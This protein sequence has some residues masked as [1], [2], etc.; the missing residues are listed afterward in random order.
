VISP[1]AAAAIVTYKFRARR[2][3]EPEAEYLGDLLLHIEQRDFAAAHEL[4]VGRRQADWTKADVQAFHEH[5]SRRPRGPREDLPPGFHMQPAID[6]GPIEVSR[7]ALLAYATECLDTLV[8]MRKRRPT[9]ELLIAVSVVLLDGRALATFVGR[10]ER[11]AVVKA[12]AQSHPVFG[13][14]VVCDVFIHTINKTSGT[15]TK[16]DAIICHAGTRDMRIMKVRPYALEH[17]QAVFVNPPPADVD[18]AAEA[19]MISDPYA[20]IFVTVP[21]PTGPPS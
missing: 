15:A 18:K 21:T 13:F 19:G 3:H 12:L 11:V 1:L 4:R 2:P 20:G 14:V 7:A 9:S 6:V 16:Q 10:A 17:G 8:A 5:M